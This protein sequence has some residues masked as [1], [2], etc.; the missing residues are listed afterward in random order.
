MNYEIIIQDA[1]QWR[2]DFFVLPK[3]EQTKVLNKIK[4]LQ[5][6]PFTSHNVKKLQHYDLADFRL[7][8]GSYR[9]LFLVHS[10]EK[11]IILLRCLHRSKL[12]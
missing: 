6:N 3:D 7:R 12:Y 9:I 8:V 10:N 2:K 1:R 5:K 11:E 4:K